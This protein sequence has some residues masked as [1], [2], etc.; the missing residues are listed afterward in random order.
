MDIRSLQIALKNQG[1]DPGPID[2]LEGKKTADAVA[3]WLDKLKINYAGWPRSRIILAGRQLGMKEAKIEVGVI[4]GLVGP[5]YRS[6]I[7]EWNRQQRSSA[8]PPELRKVLD[9]AEANGQ[10]PSPGGGVVITPW[11]RQAQVPAFYG[12]RGANQRMLQL[13]YPMR[14][15]W[16]LKAVVNKMSLHEKVADSAERVLKAVLKHYGY[17]EIVKLGLDRYS[18]SLAVRKMRGGNSWSMHSWGIAIDFYDDKNT[19]HQDHTT[20]LF[21]KPVYVPWW[22]AWEREGWVSLGRARDYDW[23]HVQAARL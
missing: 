18:G 5:Q 16:D 11:P 23:M 13:P 19:L 6:A 21:A 22:E 15:S 4:D 20:A 10:A 8:T 9:A 7:E 2:G 17:E 3:Q 12:A 14:L 1:Y